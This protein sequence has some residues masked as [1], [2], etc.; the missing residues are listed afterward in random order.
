MNG[1]TKAQNEKNKKLLCIEQKGCVSVTQC[2]SD[3]WIKGEK[4]QSEKNAMSEAAIQCAKSKFYFS[5]T[6]N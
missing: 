3:E 5:E 2:P 4:S 1:T 6:V